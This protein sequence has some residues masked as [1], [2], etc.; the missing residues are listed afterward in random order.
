MTHGRKISGCNSGI[1]RKQPYLFSAVDISAI[2]VGAWAIMHRSVPAKL[3]DQERMVE[4]RAAA[5][6]AIVV[7]KKVAS[8]T[9]VTSLAA[10]AKTAKDHLDTKEKEMDP[11]KVVGPVE[12]HIFRIN[13]RRTVA[14]RDSQKVGFDH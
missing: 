8:L 11:L 5:N 4:R 1:N 14:T 6:R 9:A 7:A 12:D 2:S 13:A 3:L 10:R